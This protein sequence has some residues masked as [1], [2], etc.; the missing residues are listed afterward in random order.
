MCTPNTNEMQDYLVEA[1]W[2]TKSKLAHFL[3]FFRRTSNFCT[4]TRRPNSSAF[5]LL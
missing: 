5:L 3:F 4:V 2:V 1:A